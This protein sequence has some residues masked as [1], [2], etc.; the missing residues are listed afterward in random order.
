MTKAITK[1]IAERTGAVLLGNYKSGS[2][3]WLD[4]RKTGIGGSEVASILGCSK[5][6]SAYT[7]RMLS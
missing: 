1:K 7:L 6:T 5:W 2:Q 4:L 3:E